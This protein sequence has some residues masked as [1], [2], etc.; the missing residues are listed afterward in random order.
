METFDDASI[1]KLGNRCRC[2]PALATCRNCLRGITR[3]TGD[4]AYGSDHPPLYLA[5]RAWAASSMML[6]YN[7]GQYRIDM[8]H[9]TGMSPQVNAEYCPR[10]WSYRASTASGSMSKRARVTID[11]DGTCLTIGD[12]FT[13]RCKGERRYNDL[14]S[15]PRN[16]IASNPSQCAAV[17]EFNATACST[18]TYAANSVSR[19]LYSWAGGQPSGFKHLCTT[20][21]NFSLFIRGR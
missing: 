13:A 20:S 11:Q 1:S 19:A 3:K 17:P 2:E 8:I 7:V 12:D 10:L 16:P 6:A 21:I 15:P 9:F 18:P 14:V 5:G 4:I